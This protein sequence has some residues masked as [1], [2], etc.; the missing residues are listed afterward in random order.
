MPRMDGLAFL[1]VYCQQTA[2]PAPVIALSAH[3][4]RLATL[5]CVHDFVAKPFELVRLLD[6]IEKYAA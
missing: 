2:A 3:V 1:E 4:T 5:P 6:L